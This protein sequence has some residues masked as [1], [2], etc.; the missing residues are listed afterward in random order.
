MSYLRYL[1][2]TKMLNHKKRIDL[3]DEALRQ[4]VRWK[5]IIGD[6]FICFVCRKKLH[7]VMGTVGHFRKRRHMKTR[8]EPQNCHLIC[9]DCQDEGNPNNDTNYARRLDEVYGAGTAEAITILSNRTVHYS[10]HEL[11]DIQDTLTKMKN[12]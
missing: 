7:K 1:K 9:P 12:G 3:C 5:G 10:L 6:H 4:Y 8:F 11:I 2:P